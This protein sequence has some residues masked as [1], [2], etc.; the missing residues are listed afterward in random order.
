MY[1]C[2]YVKWQ[3]FKLPKN[4]IFIRF[5]FIISVRRSK[6]KNIYDELRKQEQCF[7]Q[8]KLFMKV[9]E[10]PLAAVNAKYLVVLINRFKVDIMM[11]P[12]DEVGKIEKTL[13]SW[14][15]QGGHGST[16]TNN[17]IIDI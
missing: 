1:V 14:A 9:S 10:P 17:K 2:Y 3:N 12:L 5:K 11:R 8:R 15:P 4:K 16:K 6:F 7:D 13:Y